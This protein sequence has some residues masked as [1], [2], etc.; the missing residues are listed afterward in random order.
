VHPLLLFLFIGP[1]PLVGSAASLR[2]VLT[3]LRQPGT[4]WQSIATVQPAVNEMTRRYKTAIFRHTLLPLSETFIAEQVRHLS[5]VDVVALGIRFE[6]RDRFEFP[7]GHVINPGATRAGLAREIFYITTGRS[8]IL[9]SAIVEEKLD[10]LHAHFGVD[11]L[12]ALPFA[13]R[14]RLP[15]ITTFWGFDATLSRRKLLSSGKPAWI[16]YALFADRLRRRGTLFIAVSEFLRERLIQGGF[17]P[18]RTIVHY[19]GV[20]LAA[21]APAERDSDHLTVLFVGRLVEKKGIEYLIKAFAPVAAGVPEVRLEIAGEGPLRPSL[22]RLSSDCG[23]S[24]RISFHGSLSHGA[25]AALM[26]KASIVCQPSVTA[27][28]G[29]AEGLPTV[30][31]EAAA[32]AKPVVGTRHSGIPEI[33]LD[34]KTGFL[35]AERDVGALADRLLALLRNAELRGRMGEAGRKRIEEKFDIRKQAKRLEEIY[36]ETIASFRR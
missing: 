32:T 16:R 11:G 22:E 18:D 13:H 1:P 6:N 12:Y 5:G 15:L 26:R 31:L 10:L 7:A 36:D 19:N 30:V 17:P 14:H 34:G 21:F 23:L 2:A 35:V 24:T 29:D 8:A 33:I 28:D 3:D 25:V 27:R 20:D 9:D 4:I